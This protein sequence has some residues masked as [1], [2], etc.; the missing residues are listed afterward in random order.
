LFS[1]WQSKGSHVHVVSPY[2]PKLNCIEMLRRKMKHLR[3]FRLLE[4]K[5]L[6]K[7]LRNALR[8]Q[9]RKS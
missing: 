4:I 2:S 3:P 9:Y 7:F 5:E 8:H 1:D 6:Q